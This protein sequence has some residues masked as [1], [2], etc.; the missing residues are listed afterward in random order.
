MLC[1]TKMSA[2]ATVARFV[3]NFAKLKK[4]IVIFRPYVSN[5]YL[6]NRSIQ[7][8]MADGFEFSKQFLSEKLPEE[9]VVV[10]VVMEVAVVP[11]V[12]IS[13][14][15]ITEM[16][17]VVAVIVVIVVVVVISV[18]G[19]SPRRRWIKIRI[20]IILIKALTLSSSSTTDIDSLR[21]RPDKALSFNV[22][23]IS[24][25]SCLQWLNLLVAVAVS[26]YCWNMAI[27]L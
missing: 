22:H 7:I 18:R 2:T 27:R 5:Y 19:G 3:S 1:E 24:L 12:A 14:V 6:P 25:V 17:V 21:D 10:V 23:L 26:L 9:L 15:V 8:M 13:I 11:V 20:V 4:H 16:V